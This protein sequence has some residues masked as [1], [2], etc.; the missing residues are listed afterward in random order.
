MIYLL[1]RV[2][3]ATFDDLAFKLDNKARYTASL[4]NAISKQKPAYTSTTELIEKI[5]LITTQVLDS[6][7]SQLKGILAPDLLNLNLFALS[8]PKATLREQRILLDKAHTIV[9]LYDCQDLQQYVE[10]GSWEKVNSCQVLQRL[11]E[12]IS[13][14]CFSEG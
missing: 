2:I 14:K 4:A 1:K 13:N 3:D 12:A 5:K 6:N 7:S 8:N 11:L 9:Q 10:M